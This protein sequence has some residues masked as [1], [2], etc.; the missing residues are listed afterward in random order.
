MKTIRVLKKSVRAELVEN[1]QRY[2][3]SLLVLLV[4]IVLGVVVTTAEGSDYNIYETN[5]LSLYDIITSD[6]EKMDLFLD[7]F[8]RLLLACAIIFV[9]SFKRI[10]FLLSF[11]YLAFQGFLFSSSLVSVVSINGIE[12]VLSGLF[13]ILPMN[14]LN[15][16]VLI[17]FLCVCW[18]RL[19]FAGAYRLT[20]KKS[21]KLFA[22]KFFAVL[23]LC[24][25]S[26]AIYGFIYP[27]LLRS[28]IVINY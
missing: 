16:A 7:C 25:L 11:V 26:S 2:L 17:F 9:F 5:S 23:V 19:V 24:V 8:G 1:R 27:L 15:F 6:Y 18:K 22:G 3:V 4:G 13:F 20:F 21:V 12:G 10:S 14:L 28:I